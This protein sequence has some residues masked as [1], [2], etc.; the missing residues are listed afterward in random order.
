MVSI[1]MVSLQGII[2]ISTYLYTPQTFSTDFPIK[3][4]IPKNLFNYSSSFNI[5]HFIFDGFQTEVFEEIVKENDMQDDL[6]GFVLYKEN[7]TASGSTLLSISSIFG[8]EM[9]PGDVEYSSFYKGACSERGFQNILFDN[10]YDV[11]LIPGIK[12]PANKFTSYYRVPRGYGG[13]KKEKII[14]EAAVLLDITLFRVLPHYLKRIIYNDQ[15]WRIQP[16][17]VKK[18]R[19]GYF[20]QLDFFK[21]YI[22]ELKVKSSK[23]AYH[24]MHLLTPHPP[25]TSDENGEHA[26]KTLAPT[27]YN[28]KLQAKNDIQLFIQFLRKL[29][30]MDIYD[31]CLI[32][33]QADH[34]IEF[35]VR[36]VDTPPP[37]KK[38]V[39]SK[40]VGRALA[41]LAIK[42]PNSKG[43]MKISNAQTMSTDVAPTVM[44]MAKLPNK[45]EG[46]SVFDSGFPEEKE[47]WYSNQFLVTGSAYSYRS[48]IKR[49][50]IPSS[51]RP[52][53]KIYQ[54]G[55]T[56]DFTFLG[57][58]HPYQVEGWSH[59]EEKHTWTAGQRATLKIPITEPKSSILLKLNFMPY[60]YPSK[61]DQQIIQVSVN[62]EKLA[63]W[64]IKWPGFQERFLIVPKRRIS[65]SNSLVITFKIPNAT[66][67]LQMGDTTD[68]RHLGIGVHTLAMKEL[69][70][71][72]WGSSID[73]T[74]LGK[75]QPYQTEGWSFPEK[76]H[77]WTIGKSAT[78]A[79]PITMPRSEISLKVTF[80][81]FLYPGKVDKQTVNVIVNGQKAGEWV[82]TE[83][84]LQERAIVLARSLFSD[85]HDLVL[86]FGP[87]D[88]R[89]LGEV[90]SDLFE[91]EVHYL[92]S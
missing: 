34:G 35:P 45:F 49:D 8:G 66:S 72:Q 89:F 53:A 19:V 70:P 40:T 74:L 9:Y 80:V 28:Y 43:G 44:R 2:L 18:R 3:H 25:F 86:T 12:M 39:S 78:L 29:K 16:I 84:G 77:C 24:Y 63:D 4:E 62:N 17:F 91:G 81:P 21:D 73:F 11:N 26:G 33:I 61:L 6:E 85:P 51:A 69:E 75:A 15:N 56:I 48:W 83:Q 88:A 20:H 42:P 64:S 46:I 65:D 58:A 14:T 27:R 79:V 76:G 13:T 10:G 38:H 50:R 92:S 67:P 60:L 30:D 7:I 82:I 31:S 90:F 87:E 54:W 41:L 59:P 32:I 23:P 55:S 22:D 71:Y 36:M 57:N 68:P 47:R 5:I 1:A 52:I 37:G